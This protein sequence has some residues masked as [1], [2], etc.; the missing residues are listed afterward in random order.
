MSFLLV[1][2]KCNALQ[3]LRENNIN[4]KKIRKNKKAVTKR[5]KGRRAERRANLK[6][7][8]QLSRRACVSSD[9]GEVREKNSLVYLSL[10]RT[11]RCYWSRHLYSS[12]H[13][14]KVTSAV[15]SVVLHKQLI[16]AP[17][18]AFI[19][20]KDRY[21]CNHDTVYLQIF[22]TPFICLLFF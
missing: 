16:E 3:I 18:S 4:M 19:S 2:E 9:N 13:P 6:M 8:V 10:L 15:S 1:P 11:W 5:S 22:N 21:K 14:E 7:V 17:R 20:N 12:V